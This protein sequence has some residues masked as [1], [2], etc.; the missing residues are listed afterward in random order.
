MSWNT[1]CIFVASKQ[2][3][4]C[5][6]N[7]YTLCFVQARG[8]FGVRLA[9]RIISLPSVAV[10]RFFCMHV[11]RLRGRAVCRS[12][13]CRSASLHVNRERGTFTCRLLVDY[14]ISKDGIVWPKIMQRWANTSNV[15]QI[16]SFPLLYFVI[17]LNFEASKF[18]LATPSYSF[19]IEAISRT[20]SDVVVSNVVVATLCPPVAACA[21]KNSFGVGLVLAI[22]AT[23]M[24]HLRMVSQG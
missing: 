14:E 6:C 5:F 10:L 3:H 7:C 21:V 1:L 22:I 15:S 8:L 16:L 18:V 11:S 9:W 13:E 17:Y 4:R 19:S 23:M 12:Q 24:V 20:L 2:G